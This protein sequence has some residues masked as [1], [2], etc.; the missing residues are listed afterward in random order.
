MSG[1]AA[2]HTTINVSVR[3]MLPIS[4]PGR[5]AIPLLECQY[6]GSV[7]LCGYAIFVSEIVFSAK[8]QN[9]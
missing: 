2:K 5:K 3:L 8:Q 9:F 1:K 4:H 7:R 6:A